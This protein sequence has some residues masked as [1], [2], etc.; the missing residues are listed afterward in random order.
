MNLRGSLRLALTYLAFAHAAFATACVLLGINADRWPHFY[1]PQV[2]AALH[3]VTLGWITGSIL[4]MFYVIAPLALRVPL[5]A[6]R[7]DYVACFGFMLGVIAIATAAWTGRYPQLVAAALFVLAAIARVGWRV[8]LGLQASDVADG[9]KLHI[10]LAFLNI[11]VAGLLGMAMGIDRQWHIWHVS[12]MAQTWAHAHLA[13]IG[14]GVMLVMGL[15]YRLLP[16]MIPAAMPNGSSLKHSAWWLEAGVIAILAGHLLAWP[17]LLPLAAIAIAAGVRAFVREVRVIARRPMPAPHRRPSVDPSRRLG[18]ACS[19]WLMGAVLLGLVLSL[20]P[21][22]PLTV[23]LA[24]VYGVAGLIGYLSQIVIGMGGRLFPMLA[25]YVGMAERGR[26]PACS[27]HELPVSSIAYTVTY[28]WLFGVPALA[29]GLAL[30]VWAAIVVACGALLVGVAANA[31]HL[32]IMRRRAI[33]LASAPP[34]A[35]VV[36]AVS[37]QP[38]SLYG[39]ANN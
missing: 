19:S 24:W 6:T 38:G 32:W 25:W 22:S 17:R 10:R 8:T 21:T 35:S 39:N 20:L 34:P 33:A 36:R 16:M 2:V 3:L 11:L 27:I 13:V 5:P 18:H 29:V 30:H 15:S 4:G 14:W 12:P 1:H 37:I 23:A 31:V 7:T 9:V 26:P 28:A